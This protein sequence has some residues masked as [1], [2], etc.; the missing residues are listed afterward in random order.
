VLPELAARYWDLPEES[1]TKPAEPD[2]IPP[3]GGRMQL[4][5]NA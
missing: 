3:P 2:T 4:V 1:D 5:Y